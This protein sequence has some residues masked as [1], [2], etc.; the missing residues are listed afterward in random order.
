MT[1]ERNGGHSTQ[2]EQHDPSSSCGWRLVRVHVS[3]NNGTLALGD[4]TGGSPGDSNIKPHRA[5][6]MSALS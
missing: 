6:C 4:G 1:W 5:T 3:E 2:K